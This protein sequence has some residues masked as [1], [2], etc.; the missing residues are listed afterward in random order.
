MSKKHETTCPCCWTKIKDTDAHSACLTKALDM[1]HELDPALGLERLKVMDFEELVSKVKMLS[2]PA[3]KSYKDV[4][5]EEAISAL[6]SI[7]TELEIY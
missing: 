5:R 3:Q 2:K 4:D 6:Q 1:I 7:Y